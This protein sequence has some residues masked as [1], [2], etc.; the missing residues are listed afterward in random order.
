MV[1]TKVSILAP[2]YHHNDQ[3]VI[4]LG[5]VLSILSP[6]AK[7]YFDLLVGQV[8]VYPTVLPTQCKITPAVL[9]AEQ[10]ES[11]ND[12]TKLVRW[13]TSHRFID[14]LN[15]FDVE[16]TGDEP[17][18]AWDVDESARAGL[19]EY[20]YFNVYAGDNWIA[21]CEAGCREMEMNG[22]VL[23]AADSGRDGGS[24]RVKIQG[25]TDRGVVD[26]LN[27]CVAVGVEL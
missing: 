24:I 17:I 11:K 23:K 3:I 2:Q 10:I 18:Y 15:F 9:F 8:V 13:E 21:S 12:S 6:R 27:K 7:C 1:T 25:V 22:D 16:R 4:S 19:S 14:P 20:V 26:D 5:L